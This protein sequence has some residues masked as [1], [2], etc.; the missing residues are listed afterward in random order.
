MNDHHFSPLTPEKQFYT[1]HLTGRK[2]PLPSMPPPPPPPKKHVTFSLPSPPPPLPPSPHK[3]LPYLLDAHASL[4]LATH[5]LS[6]FRSANWTALPSAV[7]PSCGTANTRTSQLDADIAVARHLSLSATL[8]TLIHLDE[9]P[10]LLRHTTHVTRPPPPPS[11]VPNEVV[12]RLWRELVEMESEARDITLYLGANHGV[13][14]VQRQRE[15]MAELRAL[16]EWYVE[17]L[18]PVLEGLICGLGGR[19]RGDGDG[20][21]GG[22]EDGVAEKM[23]GLLGGREM[24]KGKGRKYHSKSFRARIE[25]VRW[26]GEGDG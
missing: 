14:D 7:T 3:L 2:I 22:K 25:G 1:S 26:W 18:G 11:P 15:E 20:E 6:G 23:V 12:L 10:A 5:F 19:V 13:R 9:F 4:T 24:G 17:V 8:T 21:G 16:G